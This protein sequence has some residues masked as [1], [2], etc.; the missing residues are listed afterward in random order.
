M[1]V[2]T[3]KIPI[4][5]STNLYNIKFYKGQFRLYLKS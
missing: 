1:E 5:M 2:L 4:E 3:S